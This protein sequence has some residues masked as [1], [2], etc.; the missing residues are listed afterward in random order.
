MNERLDD[1]ITTPPATPAVESSPFVEVEYEATLP[2]LPESVR[3]TPELST[4]FS[5]PQ[6]A[7]PT[8]TELQ[9]AYSVMDKRG[10]VTTPSGSFPYSDVVQSPERFGFTL[11]STEGEL[12]DIPETA[13]AVEDPEMLRLQDTLAQAE[14]RLEKELSRESRDVDYQY[15]VS[16]ARND[17]ARSRHAIDNRKIEQQL[18]INP[19]ESREQVMEDFIREQ[20]REHAVYDVQ[21]Q[22]KWTQRSVDDYRASVT[23]NNNARIR[24]EEE[25]ATYE[26]GSRGRGQI[27]NELERVTDRGNG[28][29]EKAK[30]FEEQ[31]RAISKRQEELGKLQEM[32]GSTFAVPSAVED[33]PDFKACLEMANSSKSDDDLLYKQRLGLDP[34]KEAVKIFARRFPEKARYYTRKKDEI[35]SSVAVREGNGE[36]DKLH[37]TL[38]S[39][40][41]LKTMN[42]LDAESIST[43]VF[44][45]AEKDAIAPVQVEATTVPDVG[46]FSEPTHQVPVENVGERVVAEDGDDEKIP[47]GHETPSP[48]SEIFDVEEECELERVE[49]DTPFSSRET[50]GGRLLE[51]VTGLTLE[52]PEAVVDRLTQDQKVIRAK[53]GLPERTM[54]FDAPAE[55]ERILRAKAKEYGVEIRSP[56]E[57][58]SF[59]K[60]HGY[61]GGIHDELGKRVGVGFAGIGSSDNYQKW[62]GVLEHEIIHAGQKKHSPDMPIEGK[63]YEAYVADSSFRHLR[64]KS[65]EEMRRSLELYFSFLMGG[66]V[67]HWYDEKSRGQKT[68]MNPEWDDPKYFEHNSKETGKLQM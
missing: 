12:H 14:A 50:S 44:R 16:S 53:Y 56:M 54:R 57:F 66:S 35:A 45:T 64:G 58:G 34:H 13:R 7:E 42:S 24:L 51:Y 48:I 49:K 40:E 67:R 68:P 1:E 27:E 52:N 43:E 41:T 30:Y 47:F 9:N 4:A 5:L 28:L 65:Q 37:A 26:G 3:L 11:G 8:S 55:Y 59:F 10:F 38:V 22:I 6:L 60:D 63:E 31:A 32:D 46:Y 23:R 21:E 36:G 33:D 2:V 39:I 17:V 19:Q 20:A 18:A 15:H 62:L 25:L 61:A 29:Q